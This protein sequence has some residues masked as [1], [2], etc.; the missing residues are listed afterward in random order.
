[1]F[2]FSARL[3]VSALLFLAWLGYLLVLVL[4]SRETIVLSRSQFL[5]ADLWVIARLSDNKGAPDED[6]RILDVAWPNGNEAL[7][8]RDVKVVN[9]PDAGAQ[10]YRGPGNYILPLQR[11]GDFIKVALVP[12]SPGY[13]PK[14][15]DVRLSGGA[16]EAER[17]ARVAQEELGADEKETLSRI[18]FASPELAIDVLI[19][20]NAPWQRAQAFRKR[21][22][23]TDDAGKPRPGAPEVTLVPNDVRIYP[24]TPETRVQLEEMVTA[25]H[26]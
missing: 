11:K 20:H 23:L 21:L 13:T 26:R 7:K 9:L 12:S 8:D 17:I 6:V 18:K 5:A 16:E 10:G 2:T 24:L 4:L 22:N 1:M 25:K 19:E 3:V 14:F 15:V